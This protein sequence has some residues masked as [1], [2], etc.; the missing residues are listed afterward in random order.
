MKRL[1]CLA[2]IG[3]LGGASSAFAQDARGLD[4]Y[5]I[6]VNGGAA[7][8]LVSPEGESVLIDTGWAGFEDRDPRRIEHVLRNVAKLDHIDHLVITHWH[9][10]HF[11][12]VEGLSNRVRIDHFWDRGLPSDNLNGVDFP[13]GP[14]P[15]DPLL[16]AYK[17]ASKGKRRVLKAGDTL[18]LGGMLKARVLAS[19]GKVVHTGG[20]DAPNPL[21]ETEIKDKAEDTS[22]NAR[23]L[24]FLFSF[25]PFAFLDCGDLTWNVEK[26]LVCPKNLIGQ[27]DLYQVTH[28]GLDAS[29]HPTLVRSIEPVVTIM[30]NGPKKG[31]KPAVVA[32]LKQIPSIEAAYQVHKN[33]DTSA[34]ENTSA[35]LIANRNPEGGNF[36]HVHVAP[37]GK[38]F[39]VQVGTAGEAKE[40]KSK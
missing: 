37:D 5:F 35:D 25:G 9:R 29:N 26:Q 4:L 21:C 30:N 15:D 16:I 18:P 12:G 13:D 24:A 2:V 38:T 39:S 36:F 14:Q 27:V 20:P 17:K 3:I 1:L 34:D 7:T 28:H 33:A 11:G 22:D 31:G 8:L 40:F 32:L 10:D 19:G 6:D 23:S